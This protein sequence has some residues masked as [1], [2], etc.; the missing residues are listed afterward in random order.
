[1]FSMNNRNTHS[2]QPISHNNN[3]NDNYDDDDIIQQQ[4]SMTKLQFQKQDEGLEIL[5]QSVDRLGVMSL[6]ISDELNFQ[7]KILNEME[8]DLEQGTEDLNILS[9]KTR[10]FIRKS[11]GKGNFM[12]I[13][14]MSIVVVILL[15]LIIYT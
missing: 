7:N 1:M 9:K 2:Y 10:E 3:N 4:Q 6:N 12:I 5:S 8:N 11:G 14:F 13:L 15:F